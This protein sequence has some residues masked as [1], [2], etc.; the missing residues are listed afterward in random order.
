MYY[1]IKCKNDCV[2]KENGI[3]K[4]SYH[5]DNSIFSIE[6]KP[7]IYYS[8]KTKAETLKN[9]SSLQYHTPLF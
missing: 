9:E 8:S 6:K 7:C 3:C 5:I 2:H 4:F 1:K